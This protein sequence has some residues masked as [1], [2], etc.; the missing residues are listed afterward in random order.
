M[1]F[2]SSPT[3]QDGIIEKHL[4]FLS[5]D[6]DAIIKEEVEV[7]TKRKKHVIQRKDYTLR[8]SI[9]VRGARSCKAG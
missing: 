5:Y 6:P 4:G 8:R 9:C 3:L 1:N 7:Y 2:Y